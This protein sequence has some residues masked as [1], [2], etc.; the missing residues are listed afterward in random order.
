[1]YGGGA[2]GLM[3]LVSD[4][5]LKHDGKVVG[6]I[7]YAMQAGGG[8]GGPDSEAFIRSDGDRVRTQYFLFFFQWLSACLFIALSDRNCTV[9]NRPHL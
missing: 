4:A 6:V 8:E 2:K 7:P 5:A 9:P 1:M 3:G